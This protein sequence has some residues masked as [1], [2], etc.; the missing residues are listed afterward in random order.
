MDRLLA[1]LGLLD[2][3]APLFAPGKNIPRA[4]VVLAIPALTSTGVFDYWIND[5]DGE[6]I[7]VVTAEANAGMTRMLLPLL[8]EMRAL[9]GTRR[10]TIVFDRG[11]WSPEPRQGQSRRS[12]IVAGCSVAWLR[13]RSAVARGL[14]AG[15]RPVCA[16]GGVARGAWRDTGGRTER[17]ARC[18]RPTRPRGSDRDPEQTQR[19][20]H[21]SRTVPQRGGDARAARQAQERD[22]EVAET[23]HDL[24]PGAGADLG[25]V[26]VEGDVA[27]PVEAVLDAPVAAVERE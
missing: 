10:I 12:L 19:P 16:R 7:F 1:R 11:G 20:R 18:D 21:R 23:R 17:H 22:R 15:G 4:G 6:P 27:H 13:A 24:R 25:A 26:F 2:D 3:A 14:T 5:Q 9:I 8:A